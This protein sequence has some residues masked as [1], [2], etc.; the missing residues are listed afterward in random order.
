M[1]KEMTRTRKGQRASARLEPAAMPRE[2]DD[3]FRRDDSLLRRFSISNAVSCRLMPIS[4]EKCHRCHFVAH[5]MRDGR[6]K[7]RQ[8]SSS[9]GTFA[10]A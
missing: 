2:Y 9:L 1:P 5:D 3:D 6:D 8:E 7:R 10:S 4:H